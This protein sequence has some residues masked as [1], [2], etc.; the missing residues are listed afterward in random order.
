[1]FEPAGGSKGLGA[2]Y[3]VTW[4]TL[5]GAN[6][7]LLVTPVY[8]GLGYSICLLHLRVVKA[9]PEGLRVGLGMSGV[10]CVSVGCQLWTIGRQLGQ[11]GAV[12]FCP[13]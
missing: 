11:L 10:R 6:S 7:P 12:Q 1:M 3:L 2:R 5:H 4:V 8:V 13:F 9:L